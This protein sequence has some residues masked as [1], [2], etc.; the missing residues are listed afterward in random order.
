MQRFTR[1]KTQTSTSTA[2]AAML[3]YLGNLS[4]QR[5]TAERYHIAEGHLNSDTVDKSV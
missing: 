3:R 5:D 2:L 4:A 1:A